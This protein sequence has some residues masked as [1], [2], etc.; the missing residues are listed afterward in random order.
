MEDPPNHSGIELHASIRNSEPLDASL[1]L[2][3]SIFLPPSAIKLAQMRLIPPLLDF[4]SLLLLHLSEPHFPSI[5]TTIITITDN[6]MRDNT[7]YLLVI[8]FNLLPLQLHQWILQMDLI[9]D[10]YGM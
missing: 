9:S 7:S 4:N 5:D 6:K 10:Q 2:L 8:T 3:P 1:R